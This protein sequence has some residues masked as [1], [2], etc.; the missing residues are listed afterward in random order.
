ML[1]NFMKAKQHTIKNRISNNKKDSK[2]IQ[3]QHTPQKD[4][5]QPSKLGIDSDSLVAGKFVSL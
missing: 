2:S 1:P 5:N 4:S 3:Q